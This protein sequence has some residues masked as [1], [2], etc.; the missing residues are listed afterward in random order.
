MTVVGLEEVNYRSKKTD[1]DV[2]GWRFHL[3]DEEP[4]KGL[5]GM[6]VMSEFVSDEIG[7]DLLRSFTKNDE[8]L[9]QLVELRYNRWGRVEKIDLVG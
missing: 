1:K 8:V 7:R 6:A 2:K 4:K 5:S 9:G 3:T